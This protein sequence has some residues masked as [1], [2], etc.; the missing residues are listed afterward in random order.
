MPLELRN[1]VTY[2]ALFRHLPQRLPEGASPYEWHPGAELDKRLAP[3]IGKRIFA[4]YFSG[5]P[6][7]LGAS[8]RLL[9]AKQTLGL[10]APQVAN[11]VG[12][13]MLGPSANEDWSFLKDVLPAAPKGETARACFKA[14]PTLLA[15]SG[16]DLWAAIHYLGKMDLKA[17]QIAVTVS[18]GPLCES[19]FM[20]ANNLPEP[21]ADWDK[22]AGHL[23]AFVPDTGRRLLEFDRSLPVPPA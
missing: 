1:D 5:V 23:F 21:D 8:S 4:A 22:G 18:H 19:A 3:P 13:D 12:L 9:R 14:R 20:V 10:I 2:V 16:E 11:K 6:I 7:A 17:G 15:K